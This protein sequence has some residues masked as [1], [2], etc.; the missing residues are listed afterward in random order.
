MGELKYSIIIPVYN[1]S[2]YIE[3]TLDAVLDN[4][5]KDTEIILV[6]DGSTDNSLEII[7]RYADS[8]EIPQ[9][10]I[11][12]QTNSGVSKA[13][14]AGIAA[15]KGEYI[16]FIDGDDFCDIAMLETISEKCNNSPD[17]VVWRFNLVDG[18]KKK[19]SQK[20][21]G[22]S[23]YTRDEFLEELLRGTSRM[24][25][26]SFAVKRSLVMDRNLRFTEGCAICEDVEFMYKAVISS[27]T[28]LATNSVLYDYIKREGS[29]INS[30]DIRKFQ[31]PL[32]IRRVYEYA[33]SEYLDGTGDYIQDSLK[34]GLLIT[35][36]MYSFD[37]CCRYINSIKQY[38]EFIRSY[39]SKCP[40]V[41]L[42]IKEAIA[43]MKYEP[44]IF[45]R[46]R[47]KLF[48]FSRRIYGLYM[49][50]DRG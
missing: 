37:S 22:K 34:N 36:A 48:I 47:L 40:E 44:E 30:Y 42:M 25:I 49:C 5:L 31:A 3:R 41:E 28:I 33:S 9:C 38:R 15:A 46:K 39:F 32:A 45:S 43:D 17:M 7:R 23:V 12:T 1:L 20:A 50:R 8:H 21:F 2:D 29:A 13:R 27:Q 4:E 19:V 24:R 11:L 35:H 6:N 14:N 10:Q 18:D 26:G 16:I